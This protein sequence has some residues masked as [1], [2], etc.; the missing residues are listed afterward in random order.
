MEF[1]L[2]NNYCVR[3]NVGCLLSTHISSAMHMFPF[4][5]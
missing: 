5:S 1:Y 3:Y 2:L 4:Y